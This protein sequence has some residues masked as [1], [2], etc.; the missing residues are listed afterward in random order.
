MI[1]SRYKIGE[2]FVRIPFNRAKKLLASEQGVAAKEIERI[3]NQLEEHAEEMKQLKIAL[4]GKF[5]TQINL[6]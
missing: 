3:Q 5:G 6:D 4:Y 2:T 1:L